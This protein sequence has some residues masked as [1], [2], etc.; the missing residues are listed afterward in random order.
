VKYLTPLVFFLWVYGCSEETVR[1]GPSPDSPQILLDLYADVGDPS[2]PKHLPDNEVFDILVDS[3][4]RQWFSTN[5]GVSLNDGEHAGVVF[6]GF[7]GIPNRQ[8]RGMV[9]LNGKIYVG[10]WGGGIGVYDGTPTWRALTVADGLADEKVFS[11]AADDTSLWAAT[12]N[13][14]SQYIVRSDRFVD[15]SRQLGSALV[16]KTV[17][18]H[19][20]ALRGPEVWCGT[21]DGGIVILRLPDMHGLWGLDDPEDFAVIAVGEEGTIMRYKGSTWR[22]MNSGTKDRLLAVWGEPAQGYPGVDAYRGHA[23]GENGRALYYSGRAWYDQSTPTVAHLNAVWGSS[24]EDIYAVGNNGTIIRYVFGRWLS[25]PSPTNVDLHG[26]GGISATEFYIVGENGEIWQGDGETYQRVDILGGGDDFRATWGAS[27]GRV[28]AVGAN[29]L[30]VANEVDPLDT[31]SSAWIPMASPTE[32]NLRAIWG[33]S[34]SDVLAVGER[35][36]ILHFNG[37][38]WNTMGSAASPDLSINAVWVRPSDGTAFAVGALGSYA[39]GSDRFFRFDGAAW[40]PMDAGNDQFLKAV[41]FTKSSSAMPGDNVTDI[42]YD[43]S[44]D[45]FWIALKFEGTVSVDMNGKVWTR[46]DEVDGL[47]SSTTRSIAVDQSGTLWVGTQLGLTKK[48]KSGAITNFEAGSGLPDAR[49]GVVTL[50][51]RN[52]VWLA[53]VENGAGM[54]IE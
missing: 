23:V 6:D 10:T 25:Q 11:L 36:A 28:F 1:P 30:I 33:A 34:S 2:N 45:L 7:S 3:Q 5:T 21:Q 46:F 49:V 4:G 42:A 40:L 15:Y 31:G 47:I 14:L 17:V 16:V 37:A 54:I 24:L 27:S 26:I 44:T 38:T 50:D 35:G 32:E 19:S 12:V 39:A 8:C 9:E 43:P 48:E 41:E 20:D 51:P 22:R 13:G 29:G 52:R 53:F 18:P